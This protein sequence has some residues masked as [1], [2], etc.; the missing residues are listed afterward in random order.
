[1]IISPTYYDR[2]RYTLQHK[3]SGSLVI[4]EPIGWDTDEKEFS[5]N[6]DYHGIFTSFSNSLKF[7]G[8]GKDYI[9]L[10]NELYGI[11]ADIRLIRDERHPLTDKWTRTYDGYLDL[12][13]LQQET[14]SISI[15]FNTSGLEKLLKA[16]ESQEI[17]LERLDT[18]DGVSIDPLNI[19]KVALNG[20]KI[21]LKSLL[22]VTD[23]D[24]LSDA[25]RR[26]ASDGY[27]ESQLAI[28]TTV[29]YKSDTLIHSVFKNQ[30]E[31]AGTITFGEAATMFYANNDRDKILN[32]D[33]K[34]SNKIIVQSLDAS[35]VVMRIDLVKYGG[36]SDFTLI[37]RNPLYTV[38]NAY[39]MN[40]TYMN[41]DY[42]TSINLLTGESLALVWFASGDFSGGL[43]DPNDFIYVDFDETV[44]SININEDSFFESTQANFLLPHEIG[45][46]LTQIISNRSDAFYSD[47]LGRT[48]LGYEQD[49]EAALI[50]ATNG[51]WIRN[52]TSDD[53]LYQKFTT[54]FKNFITSYSNV[55]NLGL[56]IEKIGYSE[57]LRVEPLSY[58]Y[59]RNITVKLGKEINGNFEYIQVNKVKR[60]VA[61]DYYYSGL[62]L[63]YEKGGEYEEAMGLDEYNAKS[64]FTTVINR[65]SKVFSALS[66]Y[67]A[68]SYGIEFA[69][70]KQKEDYPTEDTKYDSSIFLLDLKRSETEVFEQ[71]LWEDDF[72]QSPT[73][74]YS[75]ETATNLRLSPFNCLLRNGWVISSGLIKYP[76]DYVRYG[77]STANS[78]LTTKLIGKPTYSESGNIQNKDLDKARYAPEWIEFEYPVD[79]NLLQQIQGTS[80]ILGK[81]VPNMYGLFAFK[82]EKG[83]IEKAYLDNL[84]PN[85]KGKWKL[86]KFNK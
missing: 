56:G 3:E 78:N 77:S 2:V 17:E 51:F 80:T 29:N 42:S 36:G 74:T 66:K 18:I 33:I 60:T 86:L 79:F 83:E 13:T 41:V 55:W 59:N 84:K 11:N 27:N 7:T 64:T 45:N 25:F 46:R 71:R 44:A 48:D 31:Q 67:R 57:R 38:P 1:M 76:Y 52:F 35:N 22:E 20:R 39:T 26:K 82:N 47:V 9:L 65:V 63:G 68:D 19:N 8:N 14:T 24:R 12:S 85:G 37:S 81:K 58:F 73:G 32:I 61:T 16:R 28:P 70:R 23:T 6:K 34:V 4:R 53:E 10:V 43:F 62:E 54:S 72:E 40:Q 75:P 50:G 69:R 15:K 5:R 21:F 49:G 30:F